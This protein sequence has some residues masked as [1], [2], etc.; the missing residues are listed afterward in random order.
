MLE[1]IHD[2]YKYSPENKNL[3]LIVNDEM[4]ESSELSLLSEGED[5]EE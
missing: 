2:N 3:W 1:I 4:Q 5:N